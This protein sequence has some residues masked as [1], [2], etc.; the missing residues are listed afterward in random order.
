MAP[1]SPS[2]K[3]AAAAV[4]GA[5]TKPKKGK[6]EGR[7]EVDLSGDATIDVGAVEVDPLEEERKRQEEQLR[8]LQQERAWMGGAWGKDEDHRVELDEVWCGMVWRWLWG[9]R[10]GGLFLFAADR[11]FFSLAAV[12]YPETLA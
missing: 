7:E 11:V 6:K 12:L 1:P 3:R 8:Q 4:G 5:K 2:A 9:G 10:R